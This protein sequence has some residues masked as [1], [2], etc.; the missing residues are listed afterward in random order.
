MNDLQELLAHEL[1]DLLFAEKAI[2]K[3]LKKMGRE[4]SHPELRQ[5]LEAHQG[6]TEEQVR[7]LERCFELIGKRARPQKCEGI[8][9]IIREHDEFVS[10]EEPSKPMLEAF[11][12]G[13]QLRV[14][15]YEIAGYRSAMAVAKAL[16]HREVMGL[17][18]QNL[19]QELAMAKFVEGV[20]GQALQAVQGRLQGAA[21]GAAAGGRGG[22]SKGGAKR[23]AK[24]ASKSAS[25]DASQGA[26]QDGDGDATATRATAKRA[27]AR[28]AAGRARK[29]ADAS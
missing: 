29:T 23:A 5:R 20:A 26:S 18:K 17:L 13:S 28:K 12:L 22:A 4:V 25:Q 14:E 9:G 6:E 15:H 16:G 8:L 2:L 10:E 7:T 3:S 1:G 21:D 27:P 19:E 24:G 11:D